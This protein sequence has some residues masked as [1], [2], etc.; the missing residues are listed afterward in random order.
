M[1]PKWIVRQVRPLQL[2][3]GLLH[4][5]GDLDIDHRRQDRFDDVRETLRQ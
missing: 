4:R 1:T 5:C 3:P 2:L